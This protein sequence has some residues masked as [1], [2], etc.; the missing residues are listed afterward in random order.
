MKRVAYDLRWHSGTLDH[1][2]S[3]LLAALVAEGSDEFHFVC[4]GDPKDRELV[5]RLGEAAEFRAALWPRYGLAAQIAFPRA[6]LKDRIQLLHCPFYVMPL[7]A[8]VPTVVTFHDVIPFTPYA[9]KRGLARFVVCSMYRVAARRATAIVT[10]SN[11]SRRDI[12]RVLRVPESKVTVAHDAP[13]PYAFLEPRPECYAPY[14]PYFACM[15]ARHIESKNTVVAVKA[16]R[17]FRERTGLPHQLLI[18]G[19]TTEQGKALLAQAG[20]GAGCHLLGFIPDAQ[21]SSF[22]HSAEALIIPSLYEGFG[23]PPLEAMAAGAPVL[24]SN[25]A[26]LPEVCGDAALYF[27]PASAE[28]LASLMAQVARDASLHAR[29]AEQGRRRARQF[30]YQQSA[31]RILELYRTLLSGDEGSSPAAAPEER[32]V[33]RNAEN[34][35]APMR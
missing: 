9:D 32:W 1:Y 4:Y 33:A 21:L 13:G 6:L 35:N 11:F 31:R 2:V 8:S 12:A 15:T 7:W 17:I 25:A 27:N 18:G 3:L 30:S 20:C 14:T 28:E 10:V 24:S 23:L 34:R 16:W 22:F 29:L 5:Q 19:K 26:S